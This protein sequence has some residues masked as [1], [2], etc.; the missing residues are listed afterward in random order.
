[1]QLAAPRA[2]VHR[3]DPRSLAA[4]VS[5]VDTESATEILVGQD[6][7]V[8]AAAV[9]EVHPDI[10]ER[11]LRALPEIQADRIVG[12]MPAEHALRWRDRLARRPTLLGRRF[13]RSGVWPRR[14]HL[15]RGRRR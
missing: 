10:G 5:R 2:A 11:V 4:L 3:L 6:P 13:L 12:A 9:R 15:I 8:A 14:R 1:M 7:A